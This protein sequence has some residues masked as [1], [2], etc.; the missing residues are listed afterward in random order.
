MVGKIRHDGVKQLEASER[1]PHRRQFSTFQRQGGPQPNFSP[2]RIAGKGDDM[3][4]RRRCGTHTFPGTATLMDGRHRRCR[5]YGAHSRCCSFP[6]LTAWA[7]VWFRPSGP[8]KG[9]TLS[10]IA[11]QLRRDNGNR[12]NPHVTTPAAAPPWY[13]T[14]PHPAALASRSSQTE[15]APHGSTPAPTAAAPPIDRAPAHRS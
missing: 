14:P 15:Y 4:E 7:E 13:T 5:T 2:G 8:L 6:G 9:G 1:C 11:L 10:P 12:I 3:T